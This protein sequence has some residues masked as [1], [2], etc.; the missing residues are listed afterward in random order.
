MTRQLVPVLLA[1][2]SGTRLWPT[3][4]ESYP[5]Q[6]VPLLDP[7]Q[8]LLQKAALRQ[9]ELQNAAGWIVVTGDDYRFLVAQQLA[10]TGVQIDS[11][12]LEP[13]ARNTA[14]AIGLA[15]LDALDRF[16]HPVLLVQTADHLIADV[17][18][19][20]EAVSRAFESGYHSVLFGIVPTHP[21]TGYGYLEQ[22][23]RLDDH[24]FHVARF[25]EKP[26]L[27]TAQRLI[28]GGRH[29]WNSGMFLLDAKAYLEHLERF[30][31]AMHQALYAAWSDRSTDLDFKRVD[32]AIFG[33]IESRSIDHAVM[34]RI[35]N[36]VAVAYHGDWSDVGAWDSVAAAIP[37]DSRGNRTQGDVV[38]DDC[39]GVFVRA[40][41]RL[42]G[43]V[44]ALDLVVVETRDAVLVAHRDRAQD[45]KVLLQP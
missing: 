25:Q 3:S 24:L 28:Q 15:A 41:Q 8:S 31:P 30:E 7:N 12:I 11:I 1:G 10:E 16:A 27:D 5:K 20:A 23:E 18:A 32:Q 43:V 42:V 17:D 14:P 13:V 2:G 26:D 45:V 19:F 44:G 9:P 37:A 38:L 34:E 35:E 6:F 33:G 22:G 21:E 40:E 36:A 39:Q 4:R 29:L